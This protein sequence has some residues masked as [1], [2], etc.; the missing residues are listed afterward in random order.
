MRVLV[1]SEGQH[2]LGRDDV[3]GALV[4][5]VKRLLGDEVNAEWRNVRDSSFRAHIIKGK[6]HGMMKRALACLRAAQRDGFD[7]VALV[8][9]QDDEKERVQAI[10][11]AQNEMT[12]SMPRAFGV[13]IQKFD[14]WMLADET[15]W[16]SAFGIR[17]SRQPDP[18]TVDD[19]KAVCSRLREDSGVA[20]SPTE[21]YSRIAEVLNLVT[22]EQRCS[23]GFGVFA[24]RVRNLVPTQ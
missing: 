2:E 4:T 19:P 7:A 14:A 13:A 21:L 22:L 18:E 12:I 20:V 15:A 23:R 8:V 3:S 9:D 16:H 10:N 11:A 1:V 6:G 24:Q 5:L 17:V